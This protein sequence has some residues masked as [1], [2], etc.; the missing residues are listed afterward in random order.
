MTTIRNAQQ[1][2]TADTSILH[3][4]NHDAIGTDVTG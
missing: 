1:P 2:I 4:L 3:V